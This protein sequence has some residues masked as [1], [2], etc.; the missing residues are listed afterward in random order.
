MADGVIYEGEF[1]KGHFHGEGK[2]MYPNVYLC[3]SREAITKLSG[4]LAK[5]FQDSTSSKTTYDMNNLTNGNI[6]QAKTEDS[7]NNI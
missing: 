2:L 4:T 1:V 5:W 7:I 3:L 6:A